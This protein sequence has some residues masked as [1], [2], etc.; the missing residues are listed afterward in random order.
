[1]S[2]RFLL[3]DPSIRSEVVVHT[4]DGYGSSSTAIRKFTTTETNIGT[5]ITLD[6]S[7]AAT[8]GY[9]FNINENG[10][11]AL[12]VTDIFNAASH[13][14]ASVNSNQLTTAIQSITAAHRVCYATTHA[15]N[16]ANNCGVTLRLAVG[17]V[18]RVH[19]DATADGATAGL[20]KFRIVKIG[21]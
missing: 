1:M 10:L 14:G 2:R 17:D 21:P 6:T 5:A 4:V 12:S 3:D 16:V 9:L 8:L 13:F 19:T 11:Y 18:V 20:A 15:N 7:T